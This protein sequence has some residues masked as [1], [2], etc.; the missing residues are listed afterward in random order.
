MPGPIAM[1]VFYLLLAVGVSFICSLCE[2]V[3]LTLT[4]ADAEALSRTNE[5]GGRLLKAMK[6]DIDRPLAAIL[7][8]NTVSHT[9]GAAGV[10]AQAA[11]VFGGWVGLTS[12]VLTLLILV[13]SEIIPKTMGAQY[14]RPLAVPAVTVIRWM[15]FVAR[16]VVVPLE[17]L[18][19]LFK[20]GDQSGVPTRQQIDIIAEM[21]RTGGS[22]DPAESRIIRNML[23][24]RDIRAADV[25]TPRTVVFALPAAQT[26]AAV[27]AEQPRIAFSRI[28]IFEDDIDHTIGVVVRVDIYEAFAQGRT[29]TTLA[30]LRRDLPAV[31]ETAT[32]FDVMRQFADT[33]SHIFLVVDEFGGTEGVITLEDV[34]ESLLGAEI[35]DETD[36]VTDMRD[37]A[38]N[39]E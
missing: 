22:L 14:A 9:V 6:A 5:K 8:L 10:G 1:L 26:V 39:R 3:L 38:R 29:K 35:V 13:L 20:R 25:M 33:G 7:T 17:F 16:P 34:L 24:L 31:P 27:V 4:H 19:R 15:M 32:L 18:G 2:A 36:P 11:I 37:L 28:P 30:D 21:A 12:A 23:K